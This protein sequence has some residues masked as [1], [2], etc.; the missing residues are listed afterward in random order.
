MA[1]TDESLNKIENFKLEE[2]KTPLKTKDNDNSAESEDTTPPKSPD[3]GYG[4]IVV[5]SAFFTFFISDGFAYSFGVL[6]AKLL[7][8][9][10]ESRS[11]TAWIPSLFYGLPLICGPI[12][13]ALATRF[14]CRITQIAGGI[15]ASIGVFASAF[16]TSI[17]LLYFTLGIVS[18]TGMSMGYVTSLVT[19]AFY[20]E[21][22]RALATGIAV[23]G[24]GFGTFALAPL[25][26][27]LIDE[28]D[29]QGTM[30]I[31]SGLTLN[32]VVCGALLR[33]CY[34]INSA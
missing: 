8:K 25:F 14:G 22:K 20:F 33:P 23:S 7:E 34:A 28:Y 24:S 26:E 9:F 29:W 17:P 4:W 32:L 18:G 5:L 1:T 27:Y 12:S 15:V 16:A 10:Q 21:K 11:T 30:I 6:Y 31:L 13:G 2:E 19:V 3:G